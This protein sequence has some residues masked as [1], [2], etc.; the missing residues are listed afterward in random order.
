MRHI[1]VV[2]NAALPAKAGPTVWH[3]MA[4]NYTNPSRCNSLFKYA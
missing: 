3:E 4:E 2:R 1:C